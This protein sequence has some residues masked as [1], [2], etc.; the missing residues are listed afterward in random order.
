MHV[1]MQGVYQ[2]K[3]R[4]ERNRMNCTCGKEDGGE[5]VCIT[6]GIV[7]AE[8][9]WRGKSHV[10]L[11]ELYMRIKG[12]RQNRMYSGGNCTCGKYGRGEVHVQMQE[13][14]L[15]KEKEQQNRI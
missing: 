3:G 2:R 11:R 1:Q 7:P 8:K 13:V 6:A 12:G 5:S 10:Q 15:R 9:R 4:G 14:Y